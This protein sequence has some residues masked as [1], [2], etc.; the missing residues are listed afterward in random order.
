MPDQSRR[1]S[2]G[3][4]RAEANRFRPVE[5]HLHGIQVVDHGRVQWVL[6]REFRHNARGAVPRSRWTRSVPDGALLL[7]LTKLTVEQDDVT[8]HQVA[9]IG[10]NQRLQARSLNETVGH[11][12][13]EQHAFSCFKQC[14]RDGDM[15]CCRT[16]DHPGLGR[17][18]VNRLMK[19][20]PTRHSRQLVRECRQTFVTAGDQSHQ[21]GFRETGQRRDACSRPNR[22]SPT[23]PTF[24]GWKDI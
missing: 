12:F 9:R 15:R 10:P 5:Q 3:D 22:P 18:F 14:P 17:R 23:T 11:R 21:L 8:Q 6:A 20:S 16:G 1:E 13:F 19:I 4:I 24:T 7:Q 2:C